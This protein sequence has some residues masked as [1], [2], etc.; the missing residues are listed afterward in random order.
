MFR[1]Q[2]NV[3]DVY[4][5]ESRD[6]QLI[7]RLYD[8]LFSG[9]K[10]DID[11]MVN[12]LDAT[13]IKENMLQL[14]CT[15]IGF[16]PRVDI[17]ANVLRYIIASFPYIIKN[18]GNKLGIQ[19]AINAILKAENNP[20]SVGKPRIEIINSEASVNQQPY[21]VYIYTNIDIYNKLALDEVLR[22][23]LPIGSAYQVNRYDSTYYN[24]D[25]PTKVKHTDN[26]KVYSITP[27]VPI[28]GSSNPYY[29]IEDGTKQ[30]VVSDSIDGVD[31]GGVNRLV[32]AYNMSTIIG[33]GDNNIETPDGIGIGQL[34]VDTEEQITDDE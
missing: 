17:D 1:I 23:V 12:V 22:Y 14:L 15:K 27:F 18:K 24:E 13:L 34:L 16:F 10:Y 21:T 25:N 3:P 7:S 19:Y 20:L 28:R 2:D 31:I 26:A 32:G 30:I 11:S 8:L 5:N 33:S 9:V 4:I 6:F 29:K